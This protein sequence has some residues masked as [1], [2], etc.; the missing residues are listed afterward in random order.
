[1]LSIDSGEEAYPA[2]F[3]AGAGKQGKSKTQAV[4]S[5]RHSEYLSWQEAQTCTCW[6]GGL[7]I[8]PAMTDKSTAIHMHQ[9]RQQQRNKQR[10][11]QV[12]DD[13]DDEDEYCRRR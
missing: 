5:I 3:G 9:Q 4:A 8:D 6:E 1:M 12:D 13:D 7:T 2:P 10:A 11:S